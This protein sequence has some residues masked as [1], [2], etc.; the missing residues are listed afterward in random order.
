MKATYQLNA[1][2]L[3]YNHRVLLKREEENAKTKAQQKRK[4]TKLQDSLT[5]LKN[6]I[7]KQKKQYSDENQQFSDDYK[8][9]M[10]MFT[11]LQQKSKH[12][13]SVDM[14]KFHEIWVMNEERCKEVMTDLLNADRIIHEQQL[15]LK[16]HTPDV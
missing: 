16:W 13:V 11:D 3:D 10:D 15:G 4:L 5:N 2:K 12:F 8:R 7:E 14:K 9:V 6:K 1:E